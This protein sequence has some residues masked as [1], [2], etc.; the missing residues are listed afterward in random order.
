LPGAPTIPEQIA[1][2][3]KPYYDALELA[4]KALAD[5]DVIDVSALETMLERMLAHQLVSAA[6][7]ASGEGLQL[8]QK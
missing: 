4:D 5:A 8:S 7:E 2:N 6:K 3:K 1:A